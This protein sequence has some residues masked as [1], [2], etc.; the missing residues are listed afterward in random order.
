[1]HAA[2][3]SDDIAPKVSVFFNRTVPSLTGFSGKESKRYAERDLEELPREL[4]K[5]AT[6]PWTIAP[7]S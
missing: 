6:S 5:A 4:F 7:R 1:M 2:S 3:R